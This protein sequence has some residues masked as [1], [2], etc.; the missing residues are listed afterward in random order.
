MGAL[1]RFV[2]YSMYA[3]LALALLPLT[4]IEV[5]LLGYYLSHPTMLEVRDSALEVPAFELAIKVGLCLIVPAALSLLYVLIRAPRPAKIGAGVLLMA[6]CGFLY[7]ISWGVR[8]E[9]NTWGRL[10]LEAIPPL[11]L[12][13]LTVA[14]LVW[15][16]SAAKSAPDARG[17]SHGL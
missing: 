6:F 16:L 13:V 2:E 14:L 17:G 8:F 11:V 9:F 3:L 5:R 12:V 7:V 1:T 15:R 4:L 10:W